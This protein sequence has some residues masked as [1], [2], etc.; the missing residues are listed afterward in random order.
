VEANLTSSA[1]MREHFSLTAPTSE[2]R[3][4][5]FARLN[6]PPAP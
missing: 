2:S 3:A 1:V 5:A 4:R 6:N